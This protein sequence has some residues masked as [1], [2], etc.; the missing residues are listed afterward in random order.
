MRP[1][2]QTCPYWDNEYTGEKFCGLC[3]RSAPQC[4]LEKEDSAESFWADWPKSCDDHW[5][6]EHPDFPAWIES[7]SGE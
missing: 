4:R 3:R 7:R 5:C 6:G 1:T 2:C